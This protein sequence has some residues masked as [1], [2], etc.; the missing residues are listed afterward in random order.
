MCFM[1]GANA[2]FT[3]RIPRCALIAADQSRLEMLDD[4]R[5]RHSPF[6]AIH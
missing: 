6:L 3:V 1:A 5:R 4:L 2:I